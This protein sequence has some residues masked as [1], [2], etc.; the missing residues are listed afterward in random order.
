MISIHLRLAAILCLLTSFTS[1]TTFGQFVHPGVANS[2]Q[3]IALVKAKVEAKEQP[4]ADAWERLNNSNFTSLDWEPNPSEHVERGPYNHPDIGASD[5]ADDGWS[6]YCH[7]VCWAISGEEDHAEKAAEILNAWSSTLEKI[8][9]HDAR[10]LIGMSGYHYVAAAELTKHTWDGWPE[11]DQAQFETMLRN[12]FYPAVKD[13]YGSANGN[14]DASM[15]QVVIAMGVFLDDREIFDRATEYFLEGDGNGAIGNYFMETGECQESG[16]DQA[17]TQMGLDF[18]SNTCETAW[19]Q[20]VDLYGA[21]DNRLL[22]GFEYTAK[23][24]L[25]HKVPYEPYESIDGRYLYKKLSNNSRGRLR[26]MYQRVYNHYH[27]REGLESKDTKYTEE[28]AKMLLPG[29]N[30]KR[31]R[32]RRSSRKQKSAAA[33]DTLMYTGEKTDSK[34]DKKENAEPANAASANQ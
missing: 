3:S 29:Q 2:A 11:E 4:W 12:I 20:G 13:F 18:L 33:L 24:N 26:P 22:K 14:W 19:I 27:N 17:H 10:L 25:G 28:A 6:A 16:R 1:A 30:E 9:D 5:F 32:R 34:S 23:H 21:L 7:A 31:R 15:M 8:S